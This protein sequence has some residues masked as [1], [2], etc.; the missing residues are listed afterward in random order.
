MSKTKFYTFFILILS[1]TACKNESKPSE[2]N[3]VASNKASTPESQSTSSVVAF[4]HKEISRRQIDA[5]GKDGFAAGYMIKYPSVKTGNSALSASVKKW[6]SEFVCNQAGFNGVIEPEAGFDPFVAMGRE[7]ARNDK[8][9]K[10]WEL[11]IKDNVIYNTDKISSLRMDGVTLFTT[12]VP[13]KATALN[14]FDPQTGELLSLEKLTTDKQAL[15][16]LCE[17]NY[18]I[19]KADAFKKGFDFKKDSPFKLPKNFAITPSGVL[20]HYNS[21]EV[22]SQNVGDAEFTIPF[23]ELENIMDLKKYL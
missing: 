23:S 5:N 20:F 13:N 14:S 7:A 15:L 21:N 6:A 19:A 17:K 11:D 22:A 10:F 4:E 9:I 8:K 18:R 1:F 2:N 3:T 12:T 16:A